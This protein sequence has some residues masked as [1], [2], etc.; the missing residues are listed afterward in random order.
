ML[1]VHGM[2]CH[3]LE[4]EEEGVAVVEGDELEEE[5]GAKLGSSRTIVVLAEEETLFWIARFESRSLSL[6]PFA[7]VEANRR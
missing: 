2:G 4:E 6:L 7:A 3:V 5:D 1:V